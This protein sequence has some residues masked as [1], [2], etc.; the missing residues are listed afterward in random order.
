M[1][2]IYRHFDYDYDLRNR[3]EG[4]IGLSCDVFANFIY[5][6]LN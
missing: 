5:S 4:V 2:S 1:Y 6:C 3:I